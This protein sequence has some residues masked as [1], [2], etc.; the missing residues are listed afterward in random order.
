MYWSPQLVGHS[1]QKARNFTASVTTMQ[2]LASEFS[3]ICRGE[4]PGPSQREGATPSRT[5]H[6][7]R[8]LTG[9]GTLPGTGTQT[10]FLLNFSA[11]LVPLLVC[12]VVCAYP[13]VTGC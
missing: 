8:P 6:P 10:L 13:A 3:K 7:A 5:Q 9:S 12:R 2:D 1:F 4:T 11:V